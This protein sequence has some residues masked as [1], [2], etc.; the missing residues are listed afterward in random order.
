MQNIRSAAVARFRHYIHHKE[1]KEQ[2]MT[3]YETKTCASWGRGAARKGLQNTYIHCTNIVV[4]RLLTSSSDIDRNNIVIVIFSQKRKEKIL[5]TTFFPRL[6]SRNPRS[7][8]LFNPARGLHNHISFFVFSLANV[9]GF[10][11]LKAFS[12]AVDI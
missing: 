11:A 10:F 2:V 9:C 8:F 4:Y 6:S 1:K 7:S 5:P 3:G 12:L